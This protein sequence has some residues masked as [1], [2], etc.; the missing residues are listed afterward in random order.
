MSDPMLMSI[1]RFN[2]AE[3]QA[4]RNG[5]ITETQK[6]R[7]LIQKNGSKAGSLFIGVVLLLSALIGLGVGIAALIG[8]GT[9]KND[10][11]LRIILFIAF[12]SFWTL[13]WGTAG[14]IIIKRAFAKMKITVK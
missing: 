14:V 10:L 9:V 2:E 11:M 12:G 13:I 3:F 4:N 5:Q 7:L 8:D 6:E 1:L